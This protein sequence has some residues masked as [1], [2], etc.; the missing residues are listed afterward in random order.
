MTKISITELQ[1]RSTKIIQNE[2]QGRNKSKAKQAVGDL[3]D[4]I[5]AYKICAIGAEGN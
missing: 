3:C 2:E 4:N 5:R 1:T